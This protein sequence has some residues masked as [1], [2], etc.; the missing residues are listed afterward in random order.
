[1]ERLLFSPCTRLHDIL[2]RLGRLGAFREHDPE[3]LQELNLNVSAEA[4]LSA[5][6]AFTYADL[7]AMLGNRNTVAWLTPHATVACEGWRAEHAWLQLDDMFC[8]CF[9]A[10][11]KG[12]I[13]FARS[14]EH[15]LEICD[16]V[17]RL[18]AVSV[19]HS[20]EIYN[21]RYSDLVILV[22]A[23]ACLME[24][25]QSLKALTLESQGMDE[26]HCR[27]LGDY[28]RPGLDIEL[29]GCYF[30]SAGASA[31]AEVLGRNQGPTKLNWCNLDNIALADGLRGNS[32]LKSLRPR[33]S[34]NTDDGNQEV[35]AIADA[36]QENKGLLYLDLLPT[37]RMSD[38]TW[39]AVCYSLKTH[40]ALEVLELRFTGG[41]AVPYRPYLSSSH[42]YSHS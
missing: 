8:L 10:D 1:M 33:F 39:D 25:C 42:G 31:L 12:L 26:N 36:L 17:F 29:E 20:L 9:S 30:T 4:L 18:L 19:V 27:G 34:T 41:V 37:F 5:E 40:P 15:L 32:R 23:L 22:P 21:W 35:L 13:A 3:P 7:Y 2:E 38:E 28:S 24:Q 14:Y 11:D 6:R 16:I